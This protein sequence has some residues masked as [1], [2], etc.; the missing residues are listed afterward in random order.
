[1]GNHSDGHSKIGICDVRILV[2]PVEG[3]QDKYRRVGYFEE[4]YQLP[5]PK[6]LFQEIEEDSVRTVVLI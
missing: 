4:H 6:A 2:L 5:E 3:Q 1:M